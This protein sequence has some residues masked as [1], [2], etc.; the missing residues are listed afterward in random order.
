MSKLN[1]RFNQKT[2][3]FTFLMAAA[4][5]IT[6]THS[7]ANAQSIHLTE[8]SE[9]VV[10]IKTKSNVPST[11]DELD[12]EYVLNIQN[13]NKTVFCMAQNAY[14]EA[15]GESFKGKVA[16]TQVVKNR[17]AMDNY[18]NTECGVIRDMTID[19]NNRKTCQFS[20]WCQGKRKIPL[21]GRDGQIKPNVYKSWF[22][23]VKAAILV[24]NNSNHV[25]AGATHFY[26]HNTVRPSW[27]DRMKTV[28][29]IGNHTFVRP[30]H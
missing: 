15:G 29:V 30:R 25:A 4:Q 14:F 20:W 22:D 3:I 16:V 19:R 21:Y 28:A 1:L 7:N 8:T 11:D 2:A 27:V 10:E 12:S 18:P 26:A 17:T 5:L 9:E 13:M 6:V 23:S 24:Y